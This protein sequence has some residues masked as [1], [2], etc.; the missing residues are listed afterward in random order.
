[1]PSPLRFRNRIPLLVPRVHSRISVLLPVKERSLFN[2]RTLAMNRTALSWRNIISSERGLFKNS[3]SFFP[4][5]PLFLKVSMVSNKTLGIDKGLQDNVLV[6]SL[7]YSLWRML[8]LKSLTTVRI[9]HRFLYCVSSIS[10]ALSYPVAFLAN[11]RLLSGEER[12]LL[13][14][15]AAGK[16]PK[17]TTTLTESGKELLWHYNILLAFCFLPCSI[18]LSFP[19][20]LWD[21]SPLQVVISSMMKNMY[22]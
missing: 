16:A 15:T 3:S 14:R 10:A 1:M 21:F 18:D 8:A 9:L 13:S 5:F 6:E 22:R 4:L 17:I 19:F 7:Y 2:L 11:K 12:W 20:Y